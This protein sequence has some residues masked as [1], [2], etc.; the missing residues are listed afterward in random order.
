[1]TKPMCADL[2]FE[3]RAQPKVMSGTFIICAAF[4]A[5]ATIL[6]VT[7][8]GP[9]SGYH[10]G[11]LLGGMGL[12]AFGMLAIPFIYLRLR[13]AKVYVTPS[14][15]RVDGIFGQTAIPFRNIQQIQIHGEGDGRFMRVDGSKT[16]VTIHLELLGGSAQFEKLHGILLKHTGQQE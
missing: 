11:L 15:L 13:K 3:L 5:F 16:S 8:G 10:M 14:E 1:M 4:L 12:S 9:A 6:L 2:E 7:T